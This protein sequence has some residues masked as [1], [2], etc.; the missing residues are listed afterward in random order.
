MA[1]FIFTARG[2]DK[3]TTRFTIA[4]GLSLIIIQREFLWRQYKVQDLRHSK[5]RAEHLRGCTCL[6]SFFVCVIFHRSPLIFRRSHAFTNIHEMF[7]A[8]AGAGDKTGRE[9]RLPDVHER[10]YHVGQER[11]D[12][13]SWHSH[14]PFLS[15]DALCVC[16]CVDVDRSPIGDEITSAFSTDKSVTIYIHFL[17]QTHSFALIQL[18]Q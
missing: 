1:S 6:T 12:V 5:N 17:L 16:V 3:C 7:F 11:R 18:W 15:Y 4:A 13:A 8:R 2:I 14:Q 9:R 10:R